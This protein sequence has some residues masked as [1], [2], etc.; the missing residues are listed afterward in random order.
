M[1][2]KGC[3]TAS[4]SNTIITKT[5]RVRVLILSFNC[6]MSNENVCIRHGRIGL[7]VKCMELAKKV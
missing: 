5:D 3:E 2:L 1:F 6:K 7:I 4:L